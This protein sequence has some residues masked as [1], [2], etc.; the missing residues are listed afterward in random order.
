MRPRRIALALA[1]AILCVALP[2]PLSAQADINGQ[3]HGRIL[4]GRGR[5]LAGVTVTLES[6]AL[7]AS[8]QEVT[9]DGGL[10]RFPAL[11]VGRYMLKA[12]LVGYQSFVTTDIVLN[13]GE[14]RDFPMT[15]YEGLV[16]K[17]MVVAEQN[18]IDT[19]STQSREVID[20]SYVNAL[21]LSSKRYQQ[22]FSLFPGVT[23]HTDTSTAQ[24]H[25]HGG[26]TY[27]LGYRIDGA[28]VNGP[29]FGRFRLN[30]NQN[31]IE[32]FEVISGG[33][34]AE[35]GE[36]SSGLLNAITRSGS[37]EFQF[38]YS[39]L[40]RNGSFGAAQEEITQLQ[41]DIPTRTYNNPIRQEQQ[42][43][44]FY[45]SGP[46]VKDKAWFFVAGQYWQEDFGGLVETDNGGVANV[47]QYRRGDRYNFQTKIDWQV[48]ADNRMSFNLFTDP[49]EF[50]DIELTPIVSQETNRNQKQGGYLFQARDT[51]IFNSD[52]FLE[53]QYFLHHQYLA[54]R[55]ATENAGIFTQDYVNGLF[56]GTFYADLDNTFDRQ[57]VASSLTHVRGRHT[58]KGGFDYSF[59]DYRA[60]NRKED[61]VIDLSGGAG[62][63]LIVDF[64][65]ADKI[66]RKETET[67]AFIQDR[68]SLF[69]DRVTLDV[70]ARLQRQSVI[71]D[72]NVAPR[73]GV[74]ADPRGDG[75]TRLFANYGHYYDSVFFQ[76]MDRFDHNDGLTLYYDTAP[77]CTGGPCFPIQVQTYAIPDDLE[78]PRKEQW[79]VGA[80]REL[81][82][83][84]RVGLTHT[85]WET[86]NDL[87]TVFDA[88]TGE[89][90]LFSSGRSDYVGTELT[91]RKP[92]GRRMELFGSWTHSRTRSQ[93]TNAEE[94][95][96]VRADDPLATA[97]TRAA[98]DRPDV[99][100]LSARFKLPSGFDVTAIYRY[101]DG[102]LA[103]PHDGGGIIDPA[104]GKNSYRLPPFRTLDL[105][106]AK[107]LSFGR[108]DLRFLVQAFN[109]TNEFNVAG[110]GERTDVAPGNINYLGT[111]QFADIPRT[112]QLGLEVRF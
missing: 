31:A 70:G 61:W 104:Y 32:R 95:S 80:E 79:Q 82:G 111:P 20:S 107:S 91:V 51:H 9:N 48:N 26:N 29:D 105:L 100:N 34:Q 92:V 110:V 86:D 53:T 69:D 98:Y 15:L 59:V 2:N 65:E 57:R 3:I 25:L 99:I 24:F 39:A 40:V 85:Q 4:D 89:N 68:I 71:G 94:L 30:V 8:R 63:Y 103:S 13:A 14:S 38:F 62:P 45:V 6:P 106:A 33:A 73:L 52:T 35:Y 16:E 78:Q 97:F 10:F 96:F 101:Q 83:G 93:Q 36:Q 47:N 72:S 84:F 88:G 102:I 17:V 56:T 64:H 108:A 1:L 55:P 81:P 37:N 5:A 112:Y 75:R 76:I 23:N 28:T 67:A 46:L 49:A 87:L 90:F 11:P 77:D 43:Q 44:E 27:Q 50:R 41:E 7:F 109:V 66:T 21:P 54:T 19:R 22:I 58:L 12:E 18:L 60:N 42:W 74:S